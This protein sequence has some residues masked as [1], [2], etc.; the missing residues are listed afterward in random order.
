MGRQSLHLAGSTTVGHL[1]GW[2]S[3]LRH[4]RLVQIQLQTLDH[5]V[6]IASLETHHIFGYPRLV[7]PDTRGISQTF[8]VLQR[9]P[10][11]HVCCQFKKLKQQSPFPK[12]HRLQ[13]PHRSRALPVEGLAHVVGVG[14]GPVLK[15][16][17]PGLAGPRQVV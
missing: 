17:L 7:S 14:L 5:F 15:Q 13:H 8:N 3:H 4:W 9:I 1:N 10:L 6:E 11:K 2:I 12:V 16:N